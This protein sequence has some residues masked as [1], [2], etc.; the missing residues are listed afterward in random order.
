MTPE[1][2]QPRGNATTARLE[3]YCSSGGIRGVRGEERN[4]WIARSR[5]MRASKIVFLDGVQA[6]IERVE[7]L[8]EGSAHIVQR[9][10]VARHHCTI[11][12]THLQLPFG[13]SSLQSFLF[14]VLSYEPFSQF[15]VSCSW[16]G[17]LG[18][19]VRMEIWVQLMLERECFFIRS[20]CVVFEYLPWLNRVCTL[21]VRRRRL[22]SAICVNLLHICVEFLVPGNHIHTHQYR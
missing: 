10:W 3:T 7:R 13:Y 22:P 19:V 21:I 17:G 9:R 20:S 11:Q 12:F 16:P 2:W 1:H 5:C 14:A 6:D 15:A 8:A 4:L 18:M